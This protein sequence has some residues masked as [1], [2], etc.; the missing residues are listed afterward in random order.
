M[1][2]ENK[3]LCACGCGTLFN[4]SHGLRKY[5]DNKHKDKFNNRLK[6]KK[7]EEDKDTLTNFEMY[8]KT[9]RILKSLYQRHGRHYIDSFDL[10][11]M[12][13]NLDILKKNIVSCI[14][15]RRESFFI[16]KEY[17]LRVYDRG[18][19]IIRTEDIQEELSNIQ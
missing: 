6:M 13:I 10:E 2:K 18:F 11:L 3:R 5:V 9:M 7:R 14:T 16:L 1:F 17:S 19:W 4:G 12:G 8:K 15:K